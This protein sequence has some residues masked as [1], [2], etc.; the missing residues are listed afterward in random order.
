MTIDEIQAVVDKMNPPRPDDHRWFG[1]P[2][3]TGWKSSIPKQGVTPKENE[4]LAAEIKIPEEIDLIGQ[5]LYMASKDG[6]FFYVN[7][8][9][10]QCGQYQKGEC[11]DVG[12]ERVHSDTSPEEIERL[13]KLGLKKLLLLVETH[14]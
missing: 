8:P 4:R 2:H 13:L 14:G 3:F 6:P 7:L 1:T 10:F 9:G 5:W 12:D 11:F